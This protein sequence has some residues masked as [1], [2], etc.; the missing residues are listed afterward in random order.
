MKKLLVFRWL[1]SGAPLMEQAVWPSALFSYKMPKGYKVK[2]NNQKTLL[3]KKENKQYGQLFIYPLEQTLADASTS[4]KQQWDFFARNTEQNMGDPETQKIE[5]LNGRTYTFGAARASYKGKM[6][7]ITL[8][9][10]YKG[11]PTYFVATVV[12]DEAFVKEATAFS[13][14]VKPVQDALQ[15]VP[16]K[17]TH[18]PTT[19][20]STNPNTAV[21]NNTAL[22]PGTPFSDGWTSTNI[23]PYIS[24][25]KGE[26][27]GWIFPANDSLDTRER[28]PDEYLEDKY[29]RYAVTPYFEVRNRTEHPWQMIGAGTDRIW[30]AEVRNRQTGEVAFIAMRV[31]WNS[32]RPQTILS[33]A[34]HNAAMY[35]SAF[36]D[37]N[38]F[39]NVISYN[40]FVPTL[41]MLHGTWQSR[42]VGATGSYTVPGGFQGGNANITFSD[43]FTFWA[44]GS[45]QGRHG[46]KQ[47]NDGNGN[48]Y[49]QQ[50]KNSFTWNSQTLQLTGWRKDDPGTFICWTEAVH[51]GLALVMINK[52][53]T[54]QQFQLMKIQ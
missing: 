18:L 43:E 38:Q 6:F 11:G 31:I 45:Y 54:G 36:A 17:P 23:G 15:T 39:E 50:Y 16:R 47:R 49:V 26:L 41:A 52:T 4:F 14:S 44:D 33:F 19:S 30:E 27:L 37:Y 13:N 28:N 22:Q 24:V 51:N 32:G 48:G 5:I 12:M 8:S 10:R 2:E 1:F 29:W 46:L 25:Q 40:R 20:S 21:A 3:D 9:S 35:Q 53:F 42:Q 34:A 7:S